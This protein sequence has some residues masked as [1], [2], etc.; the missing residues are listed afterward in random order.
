MLKTIPVKEK[1][2]VNYIAGYVF[3]IVG[4]FV[5]VSNLKWQGTFMKFLVQNGA[6]DQ[7]KAH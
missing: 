4:L 1:T 3:D 7:G 5:S 6:L 2:V